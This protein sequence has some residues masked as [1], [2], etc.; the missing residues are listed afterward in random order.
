MINY[1]ANS[2]KSK[3]SNN[4]S[5]DIKKMNNINPMDLDPLFGFSKS[6]RMPIGMDNIIDQTIENNRNIENSD[7]ELNNNN[8]SNDNNNPSGNIDALSKPPN[9]AGR[10]Y[11]VYLPRLKA[12]D[13]SDIKLKNV[14]TDNYND[15]DVST[16]DLEIDLSDIG[17][18]VESLTSP[19]AE[20]KLTR[21]NVSIIQNLLLSP[22][23]E[24]KSITFDPHKRVTS[25]HKTLQQTNSKTTPTKVQ[26]R[27]VTSVAQTQDVKSVGCSLFHD[28][29]IVTSINTIDSTAPSHVGSDTIDVSGTNGMSDINLLIGLMGINAIGG[30]KTRTLMS[31]NSEKIRTRWT[32]L[33]NYNIENKKAYL[34]HLTEYVPM[35]ILRLI[36]NNLLANMNE[37]QKKNVEKILLMAIEYVEYLCNI[38]DS[39]LTQI[40]G[41]LIKRSKTL[42]KFF[43]ENTNDNNENENED[44]KHDDSG[45]SSHEKNDENITSG[46]QNAT[47]E[48][49]KW[50]NTISLLNDD[51]CN[52]IFK[53]F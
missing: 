45:N 13:D 53:M 40:L 42:K 36:W 33:S 49:N 44:N 24:S 47:E 50:L 7:N 25:R 51:L 41:I 3:N 48:Y 26:F 6:E 5:S 11:S 2:F 4:K 12:H 29:K 16:T 22:K 19:T 34:K 9:K 1:F 31:I 46:S 35:V 14:S 18:D 28:T 38:D 30:E 15:G 27:S 17:T 39:S 8:H 32:E 10:K 43:N 52:N 21:A 20:S 23:N 37:R